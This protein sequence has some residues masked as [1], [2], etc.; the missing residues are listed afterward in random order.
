MVPEKLEEL[1]NRPFKQMDGYRR[2]AYLEEEKPYMLPLP[3]SAFEPAIWLVSR[4]AKRLSCY[5]RQEQVLR[6]LQPN[7]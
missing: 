6:S 2:S 5:G 3:A 7:R 4:V 1:N